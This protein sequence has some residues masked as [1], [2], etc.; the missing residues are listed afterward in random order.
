MKCVEIA[1]GLA[2]AA[3]L[4]SAGCMWA[5]DKTAKITFV[6]DLMCQGGLLEQYRTSS[7]YDFSDVFRDLKPL[8]AASDYVVGN[9]E[10]PIA[11]DDRDLTHAR[12]EFCSPRA[13]AQAVKDAPRVQPS[14]AVIQL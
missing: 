1:K 10:T 13:F 7:G 5:A 6:G 2:M 9:L 8:F 12:W 3:A 14:E 4:L 11:P